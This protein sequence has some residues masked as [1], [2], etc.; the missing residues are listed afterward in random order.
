MFSKTE[1]AVKRFAA[2]TA[3][4]ES[5]EYAIIVGLVVAATLVVIAAIGVWCL[6]Q[7]QAIPLP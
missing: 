3:G 2:C 1:R 7:F 6:Q 5:T 4:L